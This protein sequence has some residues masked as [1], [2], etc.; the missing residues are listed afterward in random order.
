MYICL[1]SYMLSTE[2][3]VHAKISVSFFILFSSV[4]YRLSLFWSTLSFAEIVVSY[5]N[6]LLVL[7]SLLFKSFEYRY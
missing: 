6:F 1:K 2:E 4:F 3:Y 5:Y 7:F